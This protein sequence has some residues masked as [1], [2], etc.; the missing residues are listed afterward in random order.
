MLIRGQSSVEYLFVVAIALMMIIPGSIIFYRYSSDSQEALVNNQIYRSGSDLVTNA[1]LMYSIGSD[2]WQTMSITFP[3]TIH[4]IELY[5]DGGISE[6]VIIYGPYD[7]HAVFFTR[8]NLLN[9]TSNDCSAGCTLPIHDG[10]N[11]IRIQSYDDGVV[12]YQ[13]IT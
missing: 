3:E 12:R 7:S 5:R 9:A 10:L 11:E 13:V 2:S 8:T 1:E 6:L 4:G